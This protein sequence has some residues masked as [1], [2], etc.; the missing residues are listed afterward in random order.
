[1]IEE[2]S[3]ESSKRTDSL[4]NRNKDDA[5]IFEAKP[6]GELSMSN[7]NR[8]N[9]ENAWNLESGLDILMLLLYS[10]G[11]TGKIGEPI[12]GITRLDKIMYILSQSKEFSPVVQE[13]YEF[14]A[15][16]FGPFA[17]ELF[18]DIQA[19]KQECIIETSS[20]KRTKNKIDTADEES[21][22]RV[23]EEE[24]DMQVSWK[25]Y[26]LETY[27]LTELGMRIAAQLYNNLTQ[28]QRE[29]LKRVKGTFGEM[30]LKNLLYYVYSKAP[31]SML[32]KSK[33]KK[34]VLGH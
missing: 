20:E 19:L 2:H 23:F 4:I 22:E 26:P 7:A 3:L 10:E 32:E 5:S 31:S 25:K 16:N 24:P 15:D 14:Q 34:E 13:N 18:D 11:K 28:S 6:R 9:H 21:V 33:I 29:E 27:K 1:L 8:E 30:S 17:P 12:E